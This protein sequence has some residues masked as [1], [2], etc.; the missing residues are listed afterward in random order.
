[1]NFNNLAQSTNWQAG[2]MAFDKVPFFITNVN[3][4]GISV[5]HPAIGSKGGAALNMQGSSVVYDPLSFEMLI[6]EDLV[7]WK[8]LMTAVRNNIAVG[9]GNFADNSFDFFLE[10]KDN[11]GHAVLKLEFEGC[12]ISRIGDVPLS[13][14]DE[15]VQKVLNV[16]LVYDRYIISK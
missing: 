6:D 15:E 5:N 9:S 14:Q 10:L 16:E 8:E 12:R 4:P 11:K 1:M 13:S 3:L 7:I 2:S